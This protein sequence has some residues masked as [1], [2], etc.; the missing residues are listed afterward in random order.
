MSLCENGLYA[1]HRD[2]S[3]AAQVLRASRG[4]DMETRLRRLLERGQLDLPRPGSGA[5]W[6]R[7]RRLAEFAAEDLSLARLAE[8]HCDALAILAEAGVAP[9]TSSHLYGVWVAGAPL[10]SVLVAGRQVVQGDRAYCSGS[11][12]VD[13]AFVTARRG[14]GGIRLLEVDAKS[15]TLSPDPGSWPAIGM[16][17]TRSHSITFDSAP[18]LRQVGPADFYE[19]R[20][21]FWNGS[22]NVAACWYGGA[23][24][25]ARGVGGT[26]GGS[27]AERVLRAEIYVLLMQIRTVLNAAAEEIDACPEEL[28]E[29]LELRALRVRDLVYR[30]CLQV[31]A[32]AAELGGTDKS[33]HDLAQAKRLADLPVYLRQH[34]PM[35]DRERIGQL[36]EPQSA[37]KGDAHA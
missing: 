5:T 11:G 9:T 23:V 24:G 6:P 17:D 25:L 36:L 13:R 15:P 32:A 30:G 10:D 34:H 31:L 7:F 8:G 29:A 26:P 33:T 16:A 21:G 19:R 28:R 3:E 4:L 1:V 12:M 2:D 27:F 20:T 18:A 35:R 37:K 14:S 22:P